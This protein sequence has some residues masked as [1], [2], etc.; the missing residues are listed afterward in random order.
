V[1]VIRFEC[2]CGK[3]LKVDDAFAGRQVKCGACGAKVIAPAAGEGE[4][5]MPPGTAAADGLDAL[6]QALKAAPKQTVGSKAVQRLQGKKAPSARPMSA[7]PSRGAAGGKGVRPGSSRLSVRNAPPSGLAKNK[8]LFVGI[9]AAVVVV[10]AIVAII[11][12]T[13]GKP[14]T[15]VPKAE[16][17]IIVQKAE[18]V[19][20]VEKKVEVRGHH[21][22][23]MFSSV[24][25]E[26]TPETGT[27]T[28]TTTGATTASTTG[29]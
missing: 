11:L 26:E 25:F 21:P 15:L 8:V 20:V 16:K 13:S 9:G 28:G 2:S 27:A 5:N 3:R 1:G 24:P 29:K 19:P 23:E 22:G 14:A 7:I 12:V 6:A 10:G 17:P 4:E 18:P